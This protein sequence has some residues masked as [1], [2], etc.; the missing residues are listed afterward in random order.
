MFLKSSLIE[1]SHGFFTRNG[2]VSE[3]AFASLNCG[4]GSG[5]DLAKVG[6]NRNV[7]KAA[8]NAN[9]LITA[10]QTHSD[11]SNIVSGVGQYEGDALITNK[12]GIAL[13]VLTAD[14]TPILLWDK[15]AKVIAAIHAG[16][17]GARFGIIGSTIR[18]M[19]T[20]G[21]ENIVAAIGPTIQQSSY[22]VTQEF[23]DVFAQES[24][25]NGIYFE[26]SEK[27][28]HYQFDLPSYVEFKLRKN[29]VK[30]IDNLK[31]DTLSQPDKFYSYRRNTLEGIK[32][33]GRQISAICL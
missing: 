17:R 7:V 32:D 8:L 11:I 24:G 15:D 19:H 23:V 21:A 26:K 10:K 27:A 25:N 3:G 31:Q 28:G 22:E 33:Y 30:Q 12:P 20:L 4:P 1:V 5:D 14:C 16:W 29:G 18:N 6:H 2:G 13:G 9:E